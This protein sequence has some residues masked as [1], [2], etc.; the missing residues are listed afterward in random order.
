[1][2]KIADPYYKTKAWQSLRKAVLR[3]DLF[4]CVVPGCGRPAYAVDHIKARRAGG[5]D[6]LWNLRSLCKDHDHAVKE[7]RTGERANAGKL[8]VKGCFADGSPRDPLHPW[9]TGGAGVRTSERRAARTGGVPSRTLTY[10]N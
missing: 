9:F 3:R 4:T 7:T 5:A 2:S 8:V 10:E 6:A 1:M